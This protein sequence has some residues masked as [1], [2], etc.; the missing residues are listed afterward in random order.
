MP[1][2]MKTRKPMH[3]NMFNLPVLQVQTSLLPRL[4]ADNAR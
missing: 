2:K 4:L 3:Y 1:T